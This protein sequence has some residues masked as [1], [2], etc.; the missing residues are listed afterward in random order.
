MMSR[1]QM[2]R[3][4]CSRGEPGVPSRLAQAA[5]HA[6]SFY[7]VPYDSM[8]D[9][10]A[11]ATTRRTCSCRTLTGMSGSI[12]KTQREFSSPS[13]LRSVASTTRGR[14]STLHTKAGSVRSGDATVPHRH[15]MRTS[16]GSLQ[17]AIPLLRVRR[18]RPGLTSQTVRLR[19]PRRDRDREACRVWRAMRRVPRGRTGCGH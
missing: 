19:P 2:G 1:R 16:R 4:S 12:A 18:C 15:A 8:V 7:G 5:K 3:W 17:S 13:T 14:P 6:T 9:D 10:P 11:T